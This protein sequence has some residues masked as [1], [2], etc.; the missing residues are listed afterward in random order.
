M[1]LSVSAPIALL[2]ST[3]INSKDLM[4]II[5]LFVVSSKGPKTALLLC[6]KHPFDP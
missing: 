5:S 1:S 2:G 3:I 4:E 6:R